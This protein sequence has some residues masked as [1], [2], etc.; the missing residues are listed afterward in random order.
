MNAPLT[1]ALYHQPAPIPAPSPATLPADALAELKLWLAIS[2]TAD[3]PLLIRMLQ[4]AFDLCEAFTGQLLIERPAQQL[5]P[6]SGNWQR[7]HG[8]P[9]RA[10]TDVTG[11]PASGP[12]F[13]LA[14]DGY[15]IDLASD[16]SGWLRIS[17]PGSAAALRVSYSCGAATD[18]ASLPDALRHGIIRHAAFQHRARENAGE[19]SP[20][21]AVVALWRPYRLMTLAGRADRPALSAFAAARSSSIGGMQP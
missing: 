21:A 3:D 16:G 7:L 10:I 20:P 5:L 17:R 15:A 9:V 18:W 2:T 12:E 8:N 14:V 11:V 1:Q 4:S 19:A 6:V 13:A